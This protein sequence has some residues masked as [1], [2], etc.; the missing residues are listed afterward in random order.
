MVKII[1]IWKIFVNSFDVIV[2]RLLVIVIIL[3]KY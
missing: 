2:I 1:D 3:F